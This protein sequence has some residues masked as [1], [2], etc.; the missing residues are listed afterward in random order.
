MLNKQGPDNL[1]DD[2]DALLPKFPSKAARKTLVINFEVNQGKGFGLF[3]GN[4]QEELEM[5]NFA[6]LD[7]KDPLPE[8]R[9]DFFL[10][11]LGESAPDND[12]VRIFADIL[13]QFLN[14][15]EE[16]KE[17]ALQATYAPVFIEYIAKQ[18]THLT[19]ISCLRR[20]AKDLQ[21]VNDLLPS[22]AEKVRNRKQLEAEEEDRRKEGERKLKAEEDRRKQE[23]KKRKLDEEWRQA[24][25]KPKGLKYCPKDCDE[26]I[27]A[28]LNSNVILARKPGEG[29]SGFAIN[30]GLSIYHQINPGRA[31]RYTFYTLGNTIINE[32]EIT[33]VTKTCLNWCRI[34]NVKLLTWHVD[35]KHP[36]QQQAFLNELREDENLTEIFVGGG[37]NK[38][39]GD[40]IQAQ[41][42]KNLAN[43]KEAV[44]PKAP[45]APQGK[46]ESDKKVNGVETPNTAVQSSSSKSKEQNENPSLLNLFS[47]IL[48]GANVAMLLKS[49]S[50]VKGLAFLAT[51]GL[52]SVVALKAPKE[53]REHPLIKYV[54]PALLSITLAAQAAHLAR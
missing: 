53:V 6:L 50:W 26:K 52:S 14:K 41:L 44:T 51:T 54:S 46:K 20:T 10:N 49:D 5:I 43:R 35:I 47:C 33:K 48:L 11:F 31:S 37:V 32:Q 12:K 18:C 24:I 19:Q 34:N 45:T 8:D 28:I 1:G 21:D 3:Y 25:P 42:K 22:N 16:I 9:R 27:W 39:F 30:K 23:K 4:T 2:L 17:L 38:A 29:P 13:I 36:Q 40:K 15:H 7:C